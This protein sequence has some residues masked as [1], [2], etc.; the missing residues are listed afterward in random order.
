[1]VLGAKE[2]NSQSSRSKKETQLPLG[3]AP[4]LQVSQHDKCQPHHGEIDG[5]VGNLKSHEQRDGAE[6]GARGEDV[7]VPMD[8]LA[9]EEE[10]KHRGDGPAGLE[11][12]EGE[13]PEGV[14]FVYP[15][16]AVVEAEDGELGEELV[17]GEELGADVG[18]LGGVSAWC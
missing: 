1:M 13:Y 6:A 17:Q 14:T 12:A 8:R 16:D 4:H 18:A 2:T 3:A 11:D 10:G 5:R 9:L 15:E 7:P